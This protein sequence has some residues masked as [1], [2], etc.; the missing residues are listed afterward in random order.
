MDFSQKYQTPLLIPSPLQLSTKKYTLLSPASRELY[1]FKANQKLDIVK[2]A[3]LNVSIIYLIR[4]LKI[5]G[6]RYSDH[7]SWLQLIFRSDPMIYHSP[8][9]RFA[10]ISFLQQKKVKHKFDFLNFVPMDRI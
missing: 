10:A 6:Q 1:I 8:R 5:R 4:D 2:Y 3:G 9:A 7:L